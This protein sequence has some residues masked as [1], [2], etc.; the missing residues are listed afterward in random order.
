M[1]KYMCPSFTKLLEVD[2]F[3]HNAFHLL[4][5]TRISLPLQLPSLLTDA[6]SCFYDCYFIRRFILNEGKE[7]PLLH[8]HQQ[9]ANI[10]GL[11]KYLA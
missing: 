5:R 8:A 10:M 7:H 6:A 2:L 4:P 11:C 1:N 9:V 3:G